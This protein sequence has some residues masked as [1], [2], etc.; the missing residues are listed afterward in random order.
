MAA[1]LLAVVGSLWTTLACAYQEMSV[2]DGGDITGRVVYDGPPPVAAHLPV[3][4]NRDFCGDSAPDDGLVVGPRRGLRFVVV[5]LDGIRAGK[6]RST[7]RSVLD[8][9]GCAFVPHVQTMT[10]GQTLSLRNSDPILH[11]AHARVDGFKTLFNLGLPHWADKTVRFTQPGRV[12][13]DCDVLHTWMR[14]YIVVTEH[15]Y[16]DV[17][18]VNGRFSLTRVPAGDYTLRFWHERLGEQLR[19]VAVGVRGS[20]WMRVAYTVS[21]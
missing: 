8:N 14:A 16:V 2:D 19:R 5:R 13:V 20:T 17:T 11:N 18:D 21:H 10:V 4:K 15:P 3:H 6:P 7:A 12:V 1:I 9:V